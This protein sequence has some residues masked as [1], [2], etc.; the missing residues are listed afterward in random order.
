MRRARKNSMKK[1]RKVAAGST[2]R[3]TGLLAVW[4]VEEV[5]WDPDW[6]KGQ[7]VTLLVEARSCAEAAK[8][9]GE[10]DGIHEIRRVVNIGPIVVRPANTAAHLR[11]GAPAEPR[12][13]GGSCCAQD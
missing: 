7:T 10:G 3:S 2:S 13:S 6:T 1:K 4:F 8:L 9:A 11:G 5:S 12:K